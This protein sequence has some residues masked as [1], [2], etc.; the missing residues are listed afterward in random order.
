MKSSLAKFIT[1][2]ANDCHYSGSTKYLIVNWVHPLFLKAKEAASKEDNPIRCQAMYGP[3]ANEYWKA[4]VTDVETLEAMNAYI[5]VDC[6][7]D[8]NVLQSTWAFKLK[9]LCDGLLKKSKAWFCARGDQQIEGIDF[10]ET[11]APVVKWTTICL[12]LILEVLLE[13]NSK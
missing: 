5:V 9:F 1:F 10:G 2:S 13:L 11:Y 12:M 8:M 6:N 3:F 4:A 7:E